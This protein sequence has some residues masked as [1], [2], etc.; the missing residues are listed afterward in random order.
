[1]VVREEAGLQRKVG[2]SEELPIDFPAPAPE[3]GQ[4]GR[5]LHSW[6]EIASYIGRGIRTVQRWEKQFMFP[7]HRVG[8]KGA[9]FAF[10]AEIDAWLRQF[11]VNSSDGEGALR[12][13]REVAEEAAREENPEKLVQLIQE[14]NQLLQKSNSKPGKDKP[15]VSVPPP[16]MNTAA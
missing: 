13:W 7:V 11:A 1:M 5:V 3:M 4:D 9:V 12:N 6:K 10:P 16:P 8:N 15:R 2:M 14:L